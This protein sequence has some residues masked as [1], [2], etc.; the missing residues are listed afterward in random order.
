MLK[1]FIIA[2]LFLVLYQF[3]SYFVEGLESEDSVSTDTTTDASTDTSGSSSSSS[4]NNCG[5]SLTDR[6]VLL[7]NDRVNALQVQYTDLSSNIVILNKQ[8]EDLMKQN[9]NA[10]TEMVG[11]Q[12]LDISTSGN[13]LPQDVGGEESTDLM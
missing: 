2:V 8:M 1:I 3:I 11:D 13:D 6:N 9:E 10:A 4:N 5:I 12:P 7:L